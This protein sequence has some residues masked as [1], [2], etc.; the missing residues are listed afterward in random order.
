VRI[1]IVFT[2][3]VAAALALAFTPPNAKMLGLEPHTLA[4][5]VYAGTIVFVLLGGVLWRHEGQIREAAADLT[6]WL[7]L[8]FILVAGYSN[9]FELANAAARVISELMP[10]ATVEGKGGTVLVTRRLDGNFVVRMSVNGVYLPFVFDTGASTVV[11]R[12]EDAA[13]V[14]IVID[15]LSFQIPISTANGRAMAAEAQIARM[16][17]G[18]ISLLQVPAL[19]TKPG[20]LNE[21]LLGMSFLDKLGSFTVSGDRLTLKGR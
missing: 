11:I 5:G 21:N 18:Q 3:V 17:V 1:L 19:V 8:L 14:G 12:A 16:S 13:K 4:R 2:F 15:D 9:R 7:L 10:G 6:I 20:T